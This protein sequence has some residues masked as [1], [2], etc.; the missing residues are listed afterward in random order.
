[1]GPAPP[2]TIQYAVGRVSLWGVVIE[3]ERGWR[4]LYAYPARL[5][6][7]ERLTARDPRLRPREVAEGLAGYGVPVTLTDASDRS[8]LLEAIEFGQLIA[9]EH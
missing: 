3:C 5:Y 7:P 6:L 1:M 9:E 8:E 2:E 4:A